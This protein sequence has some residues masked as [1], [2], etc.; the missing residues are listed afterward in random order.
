[1]NI[2]DKL[3]RTN[4]SKTAYT[5]LNRLL[6]VHPNKRD[7]GIMQSYLQNDNIVTGQD[8]ILFNC[9]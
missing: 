7:G 9:I 6:I 1:M 4:N 3:L 5:M 2:I 8:N